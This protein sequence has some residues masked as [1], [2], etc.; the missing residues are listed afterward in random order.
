LLKPDFSA[1]RFAVDAANVDEDLTFTTGLMYPCIYAVEN[2]TLAL[3]V[4]IS[5]HFSLEMPRRICSMTYVLGKCRKFFVVVFV[6]VS[7]V[8]AYPDSAN[9]VSGSFWKESYIN[10]I[11]ATVN[12]RAITAGE[13]RQELAPLLQKI[14][15]ECSTQD[16]FSARLTEVARQVL[17][18]IIDRILMIQEF[19]KNGNIVPD[20][21]KNFQLDEFIRTRFNGDRALFVEKL[22]SYGKSLQQFK[23]EIEEGF[24]VDLMLERIRRSGAIISPVH[25]REYYETHNEE[26]YRPAAVRLALI[27]I[28]R[29]GNGV[30]SED[31]LKR[32]NGGE[33]FENLRDQYSPE[34]KKNDDVWI[35]ISSLDKELATQI[36]VAPVG[37]YLGPINFENC[38]VIASVLDHRAG[39]KLSFDETRDEIEWQLLRKSMMEARGKWLSS[40]RQSA[41]IQIFI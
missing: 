37:T 24:I 1:G 31:I 30:V 36:E 19:E 11:V 38:V 5:F 41:H 18:G 40:L 20:M 10:G 17:D 14:E 2:A 39:F 6:F 23:R 22:H 26:F 35:N 32:L 33:S 7:I 9:S 8:K 28:G 13:L 21:Q 15:S 27:L 25:V 29:D 3:C 12:D 4:I 16:D 34:T